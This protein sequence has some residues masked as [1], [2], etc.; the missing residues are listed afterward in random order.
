MPNVISYDDAYSFVYQFRA[1][2]GRDYPGAW[3]LRR[4][5]R[6]DA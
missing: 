3:N 1:C 6:Y 4:R 5:D 2:L